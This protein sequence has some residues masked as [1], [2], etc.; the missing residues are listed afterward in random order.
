MSKFLKL[1]AGI[2]GAALLLPALALAADAGAA[3]D[4]LPASARGGGDRLQLDTTTIKAHQGLPRVMTIVP[5]KRADSGELPGRPA[6]SLLDEVLA[7]VDRAEFRRQ[8]R[9]TQQLDAGA[10]SPSPQP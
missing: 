8:L 6:A 10:A 9:Y 1:C 2:A 7:P 5:W 4:S 3:A